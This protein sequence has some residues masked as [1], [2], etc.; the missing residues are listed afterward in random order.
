M[1][2]AYNAGALWP[3]WT[4]APESQEAADANDI[5]LIQPAVTLSP[6]EVVTIQAES[7]R[8]CLESERDLWQCY[9]F[10]SPANRGVTGPIDRFA[11]MLL[12]P[13]YKSLVEAETMIIGREEVR[14]HLATVLVTVT[15]ADNRVSSYRFFLAKQADGRVKDCWMT[16]GVIAAEPPQPSPSVPSP[17]VPSPSVP[18]PSVRSSSV[19]RA[20]DV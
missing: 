17:S 5:Q 12:T 6:R 20:T 3:R 16:E 1:G 11:R 8:H 19:H 9:L 18:S 2:M 7:L 15:D 14:S 10:A 13:T 4:P